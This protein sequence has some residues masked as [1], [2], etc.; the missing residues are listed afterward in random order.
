MVL[1]HRSIAGPVL[2]GRTIK[3]LFGGSPGARWWS[4]IFSFVNNS[5]CSI[6]QSPL[7][8]SLRPVLSYVCYIGWIRSCVSHRQNSD[9]NRR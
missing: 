2:L 4:Q 7:I 1:S 8:A 3:A 9:E 6:G 5:S